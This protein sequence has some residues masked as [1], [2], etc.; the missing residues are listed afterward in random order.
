MTI[1]V[2]NPEDTNS[3]YIN[4]FQVHSGVSG[5]EKDDKCAKDANK[6]DQVDEHRLR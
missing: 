6:L 3:S 4:V 2:Q 1:T 5:N